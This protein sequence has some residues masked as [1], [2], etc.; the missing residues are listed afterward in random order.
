M[1]GIPQ[2]RYTKEFREEAVKLVTEEK[3]SLSE[4]A[5]RL[6]LAPST[7]GNWVKAY[8]A[9]RLGEVG[10]TYKPLT[11]I[12]MDLARTKKELAEVKMERDILKK[13]AAYFGEGVAARY[14][15]MK[16]LRLH[17]TLP[18]VRRVLSV[19]A[20]GYYAWQNR[21]LSKWSREEERLEVE[22][23]AAHK[24]T[25]QVCGAEKLQHD[26]AE[27]GIRVGVCRIRRIRNKLGIRC[28]QK[29]KFKATTDSRHTLPVAENILGQQFMVTAPNKV[30]VSDIT[31]VPTDKGWLYV[32]GHK[33]LYAG[34]IVGYAMGE[35]LTRN[36][37]SQSLFKALAAKR[38]AKGLIHHSDRGSQYCSHEYR[39]I[40][41]RFG[42][43][44]SMSRKG[45]CFDN[46]PIESFW[47]TL[48]QELVH[49]RR[50]RTRQE[51]IRD[52]TKYIE[53]FYNRQRRQARLGLR[54]FYHRKIPMHPV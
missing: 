39:N 2:G 36:L 41:D 15:S 14:A 22:I 33:D 53:V 54:L 50:Y 4:A 9:G 8:K 35:R 5:R 1:K 26:L 30:W 32:A 11:E 44:A 12:E 3:L 40:M 29:K 47:G 24:R 17:Y 27:H 52:I 45:N 49:H 16:E 13:A 6:S 10:K 19:S 18:L 38:P 43:K 25:R 34:D 20:S 51:A 7:L 37:I 31:Y 42:L 28:K 48:K 46:A 21:P 23:R